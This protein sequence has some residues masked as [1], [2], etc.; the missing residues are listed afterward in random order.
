MND[1]LYSTSSRK[2]ELTT[3]SKGQKKTFKQMVIDM[4]QELEFYGRTVNE[5]N[6]AL[7]SQDFDKVKTL[8]KKEEI[9]N[10]RFVDYNENLQLL[11]KEIDE[12][13]ESLTL[14]NSRYDSNFD[15]LG[16]PYKSLKGTVTKEF[17][18]RKGDQ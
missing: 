17:T 18:S 12:G 2:K 15:S 16:S 9:R 3:R 7:E 10:E 4:K 5:M 11:V 8:L 1:Y 6:E 14:R 13:R